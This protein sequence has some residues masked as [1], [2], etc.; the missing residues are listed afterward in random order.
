MEAKRSSFY[1]VLDRLGYPKWLADE[2]QIDRV[3]QDLNLSLDNNSLMNF[4]LVRR[5]QKQ[6]NLKKLVTEKD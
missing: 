5:F 1:V 3:Y 6:Q 4:L 2:K